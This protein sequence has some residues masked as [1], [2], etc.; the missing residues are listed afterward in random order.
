MIFLKAFQ[1]KLRSTPAQ[2][3]LFRQYAGAVRWVWNEMRHERQTTYRA[4]GKSSPMYEQMRR[5]TT[6]KTQPEY[7]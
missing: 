4:A 2:E 5:L 3:Q 6:L 1:F 7:A